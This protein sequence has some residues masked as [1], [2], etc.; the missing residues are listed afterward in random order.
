[1]KWYDGTA[2]EAIAASRQ[3]KTLLVVYIERPSGVYDTDSIT[4]SR[5]WAT[6]QNN[7]SDPPLV[8]VRL[9]EGSEVVKQFA[10]I[11]PL[12]VIPASYILDLSGRPLDVITCT[13]ELNER[14]FLERLKMTVKMN[15]RMRL[16]TPRSSPSRN[17][18]GTSAGNIS[19][20][21][22]FGAVRNRQSL[23]FP[24]PGEGPRGNARRQ[25]ANK[26]EEERVKLEDEARLKKLRE[27]IK[28]DREEQMKK[29]KI[30]SNA[31][32]SMAKKE[33]VGQQAE[34]KICTSLG[35]RIQCRFTDGSTLV[36]TFATDDAFE[37]LIEAVR[38]DGRG[39]KN[40][41]L[42][43]MY[44]RKEFPDVGR[45]FAEL[46]LVPSATIL[47]IS[48]CKR[49]L[50][51]DGVAEW[52]EFLRYVLLAP[53]HMFYGFLLMLVGRTEVAGDTSKKE[54]AEHNGR[55][56][57]GRRTSAQARSHARLHVRQDGNTFRFRN[58]DDSAESD[59]EARWNGNSTQQ[60]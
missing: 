31:Q 24:R 1:M 17:A 34:P 13:P 59:D 45:T 6:V 42:V 11:Y 33:V 23:F 30:A 28:A 48:K 46:G 2:A 21:R 55:A 12:P 22:S 9:F 56:T 47:V 37:R 14:I 8:G 7:I 5:L 10:R 51:A 15:R 20:D 29:F 60:L 57:R 18:V 44:P 36:S 4:M 58:H 3:L 25:S 52:L 50:I 49:A 35:C 32:Q 39:G 26:I 54:N 19:D 16:V 41:D 38:H 27:Q 43:Q 53:L 40:F